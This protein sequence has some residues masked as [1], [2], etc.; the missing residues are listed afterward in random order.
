MLYYL[1]VPRTRH[2]TSLNERPVRR[3]ASSVV[4]H[5]SGVSEALCGGSSPFPLAWLSRSPFWRHSRWTDIGALY[6]ADCSILDQGQSCRRHIHSIFCGPI[7]ECYLALSLLTKD[8][9]AFLVP[10]CMFSFTISTFVSFRVVFNYAIFW[11]VTGSGAIAAYLGVPIVYCH[12]SKEM[13]LEALALPAKN[14]QT[15]AR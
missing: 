12:V 11:F 5:D 7:I 1:H 6:S 14:S 13:T 8:C 10:C 15:W 4:G 3:F 2:I 9:V